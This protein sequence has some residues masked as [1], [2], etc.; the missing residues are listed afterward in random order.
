ME[1]ADWAIF[2]GIFGGFLGIAGIV[3]GIACCCDNGCCDT[4]M[5]TFRENYLERKRE[6]AAPEEEFDNTANNFRGLIN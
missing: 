3:M 2:G 5:S 1:A 4:K 6:G